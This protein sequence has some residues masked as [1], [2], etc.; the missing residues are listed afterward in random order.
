MEICEK[1][2]NNAFLERTRLISICFFIIMTILNAC[3]LL[4]N[5]KFGLAYPKFIKD[6]FEGF[7]L[8]NDSIATIVTYVY[9]FIMRE[10][11]ICILFLLI[12]IPFLIHLI[13]NKTKK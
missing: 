4:Y 9:Y 7:E 10:T 12:W 1:K 8:V 3:L 5:I 13:I 2:E 11:M 6:M